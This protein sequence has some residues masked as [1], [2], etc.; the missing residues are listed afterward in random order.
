MG[1]SSCSFFS[2]PPTN[3]PEPETC[4]A[5][6]GVGYILV[7]SVADEELEEDG[8]VECDDDESLPP[9]AP[10]TRPNSPHGEDEELAE[11]LASA[12]DV[13][14]SSVAAESDGG[15]ASAVPVPSAIPVAPAVNPGPAIVAPAQA[16]PATLP[17]PV[18]PAGQGPP[19]PATSNPPPA[20]SV[21]PASTP[22]PGFSPLG[23]GTPP[24][25]PV[26][27]VFADAAGTLD[28]PSWLS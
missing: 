25:L 13:S 14:V 6:A 17:P 19:V 1:D 11:Y 18:N 12:L 10:P 3:F 2:Y 20:P 5:C 27:A 16:G 23:P 9:L 15:S 26:M 4:Q 22:I 24:P 28:Y 8:Y 21:P 7:P